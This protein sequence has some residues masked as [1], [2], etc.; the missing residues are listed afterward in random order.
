M[1]VFL[2]HIYI[3][4]L[5][6]SGAKRNLVALQDGTTYLPRN[7]CVCVYEPV[8]TAL[9]TNRLESSA[10]RHWQ[11]NLATVQSTLESILRETWHV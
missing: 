9:H 4:G 5:F 8:D 3:R 11:H 7:V 2:V 1:C 6:A 10:T